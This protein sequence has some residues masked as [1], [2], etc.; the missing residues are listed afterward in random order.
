[1]YL[2]RL[3]S[4]VWLWARNLQG[5]PKYSDPTSAPQD[6]CAD[7]L[8][9]LGFGPAGGT[10]TKPRLLCGLRKSHSQR[11]LSECHHELRSRKSQYG[12]G[13]I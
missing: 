9:L 3:L 12:S 13:T 8:L 10:G 6:A 4:V 1:M 2:P 7:V 5:P 11:V